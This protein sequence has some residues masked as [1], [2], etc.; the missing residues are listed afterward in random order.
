MSNENESKNLSDLKAKFL[1][2]NL[3]ALSNIAPNL[4]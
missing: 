3:I 4:L 2:L 1:V